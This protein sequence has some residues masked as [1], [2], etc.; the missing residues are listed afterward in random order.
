MK[1][2][3]EHPHAKAFALHV[4]QKRGE[5]GARPSL[6]AYNVAPARGCMVPDLVSAFF[7]RG[8]ARVLWLSNRPL[9][10]PHTHT[11]THTHTHR[12]RR[13]SIAPVTPV[14]A[15]PSAEAGN[16]DAQNELGDLYYEGG[17]GMEQDRAESVK[18]F[19]KSAA[20]GNV[21]AMYNLGWVY[22]AGEGVA[23]STA[24]A[25]RWYEKAVAKNHRKAHRN[26]APILYYGMDGIVVDKRR[27]TLLWEKA[28]ELGDVEAA[29]LLGKLYMEGDA[30]TPQ[31]LAQGIRYLK[32]AAHSDDG[33]SMFLLAV[34]YRDGQGVARNNA[35][36]Q[37]WFHKARH[38]FSNVATYSV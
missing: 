12:F 18:W 8:A 25:V 31:D 11:H 2:A 16:A 26:L 7:V 13:T 30:D 9:A 37:E 23:K 20:Q 17:P 3:V 22:S 34:A 28:V 19:S 5:A 4:A 15:S 6:H 38:K 24:E 10:I 36:A 32:V 29:A 14:A 27:G 21:E 33:Y 1:N 35:V